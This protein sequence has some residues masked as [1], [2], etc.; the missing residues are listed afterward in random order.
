[1]LALPVL[2][3]ALALVAGHYGGYLDGSWG[4]DYGLIKL[5]SMLVG[6]FVGLGTVYFYC[7]KR[8]QPQTHP[9]PVL[10]GLA[11]IVYIGVLLNLLGCLSWPLYRL[12]LYY[13]MFT[14]L[15]IP[16]A[17]AQIKKRP[18][19]TIFEAIAITGMC[20]LSVCYYVVLPNNLLV[21]PFVLA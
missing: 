10:S 6:I 20:V 9:S 15:L 14:I 4:G 1:M 18:E 12:F 8:S 16:A 13:A 5:T 2:I 7:L 21:V 17:I 11:L 19:R 3:D